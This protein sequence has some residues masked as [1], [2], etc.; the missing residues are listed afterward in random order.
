[1]GR[2]S[3]EQLAKQRLM[4]ALAEG[5]E[6]SKVETDQGVTDS[7]VDYYGYDPRS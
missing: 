3:W 6:V 1:M 7:L 2:F 5:G 4:K